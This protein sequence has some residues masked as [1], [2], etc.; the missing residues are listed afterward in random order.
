MEKDAVLV[1][2]ILGF[3]GSVAVTLGFVANNYSS[4]RKEL[5]EPSWKGLQLDL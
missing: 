5:C 1:C 2:M 4:K 3:L